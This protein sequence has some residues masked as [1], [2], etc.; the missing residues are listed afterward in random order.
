MAC[1]CRK[2]LKVSHDFLL[3]IIIWCISLIL[4]DN[5]LKYFVEISPFGLWVYV[6]FTWPFNLVAWFCLKVCFDHIAV[7]YSCSVCWCF[8]KSN[9]LVVK[10]MS[11]RFSRLVLVWCIWV[12]ECYTK[13]SIS[14][15]YIF[16]SCELWFIDMVFQSISG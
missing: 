12:I 11:R 15:F 14:V 6:A 16:L 7:I 3:C 9:G 8:G 2:V 1:S 4:V 13:T 5:T 10:T